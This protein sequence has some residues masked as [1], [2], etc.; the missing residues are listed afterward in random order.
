MINKYQ[1]LIISTTD[2]VLGIGGPVSKE[3]ED[4]IYE[5]KGRDRNKKLIILVSSI[6]QARQF[7]EWNSQADEFAKKYWPGAT[8]IVVNN[9]G[10]RMPNQKK[11][12]EYIEVNGPIYM[13]S[14]NLSNA[15]VCKTIENAKQL[16]PEVT[17]VYNFG[18]MTQKP[19]QIIRVE[20]GEILRK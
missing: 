4:L 18:P 3:V 9:Q 14:C 16:F 20:D 17:N 15:P 1:K 10:F 6:K 8:T 19:S 7:K 2:T 12:L 11:L 13:T 5:I